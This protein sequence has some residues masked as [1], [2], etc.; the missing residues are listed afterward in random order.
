MSRK[1]T[2]VTSSQGYNITVQGRHVQV[3]DAMK[4]HVIEKL[5]K[6]EKFSDRI[7]EVTVTMDIQKLDHRVD[8]VMKVNHWTIKAS[9]VTTE[10]YA[11]IDQAVHKLEK[12]VRRYKKKIQ[13]HQA[14][15]LKVVDLTVNVL[16]KPELDEVELVNEQI[17][18]E[19]RRKELEEL[20]PH[21]VVDTETRPLKI[22]TTDE[23][24]AK[25]ELS[26]DRFLLYRCEEDQKLKVIYRRTDEN[27]GI[28]EAEG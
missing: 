22:L 8:I 3:T 26:G 23:A 25:M 12:Q 11:S 15:G 1:T 17:E 24:I 19:N 9:A 13:D 20:R 16:R 27:Y 28:I 6:L 7:I 21:E 5:S 14:R 10:M 4:D 2:T 18:E